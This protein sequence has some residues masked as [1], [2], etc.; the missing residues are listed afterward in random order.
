MRSLKATMSAQA[1]TQPQ[2]SATQAR[3][4]DQGPLRC[5]RCRA[6]KFNLNACGAHRGG[7]RNRSKASLRRG[8]R[9]PRRR[10]L[11]ATLNNRLRARRQRHPARAPY[12]RARLLAR[13]PRRT[14]SVRMSRR[15]D[16][17]RPTSMLRA[18]KAPT[19]VDTLSNS[20]RHATGACTAPPPSNCSS[21]SSSCAC[22]VMGP[23]ARR[24]SGVSNSISSSTKTSQV[25]CLS[26][27]ARRRRA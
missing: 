11:Y 9:Q 13:K 23:D 8:A 5:T 7:K 21:M 27:P 18:V 1:D 17:S 26:L 24:T 4:P 14:S 12:F 3:S 15:A 22:R 16:S 19:L 20:S 25:R 6:A 2:Y 10:A